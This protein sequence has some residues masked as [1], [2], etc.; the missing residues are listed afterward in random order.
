MASVD[1]AHGKT[2][3]FQS[4]MRGLGASE[5]RSDAS[6]LGAAAVELQRRM[7]RAATVIPTAIA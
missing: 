1:A 3:W 5:P 6:V 7:S 2:E 4:E